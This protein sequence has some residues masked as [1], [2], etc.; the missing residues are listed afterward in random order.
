LRREIL[1]DERLAEDRG[2]IGALE[3]LDSVPDGSVLCSH[4]DVIPETMAALQRR[5]C[6]IIGEPDWRKGTIWALDRSLDG[7]VITAECW[8]PP[9]E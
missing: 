8:P 6:R 5:G 1:P 9:E 7:E 3:L 2:F 4:G